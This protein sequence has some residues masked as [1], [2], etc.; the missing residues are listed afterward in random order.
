MA[1]NAYLK[2]RGQRQG[3]ILGSVTQAG[4][5]GKIMVFAVEHGVSAPRD[6]ASGLPTGKR[7]H[8]PIKLT[9]EI[10]RSTPK[11]YDALVNNESLLEWELQFWRPGAGQEEQHYT[12]RLSNGAIAAIDFRMPDNKDPNLTNLESYEVVSFVYQR[13]RWEWTD[14]AVTFE[15]AWSPAT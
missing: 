1:L 13:I 2:L 11:L 10:D 15:D 6:P 14:G 7:A 8:A 5:A 3:D 12:V 4:Q 9:K